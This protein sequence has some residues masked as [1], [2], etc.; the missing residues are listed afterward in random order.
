MLADVKFGADPLLRMIAAV[1]GGP[2]DPVRL[3]EGVYLCGHWNVGD[4]CLTPLKEKWSTH[5]GVCDTPEQ[6]IAHH[7][8]ITSPDHHFLAVN[9]IRRAEQPREGGWRWHKWGPYIGTHTPTCEYLHDEPEI[10][11]VYTYSVYTLALQGDDQ[12]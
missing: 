3:S 7:S 9:C 10:E 8:L 4:I 2:P 1:N 11:Q 5:H 12:L 6:A